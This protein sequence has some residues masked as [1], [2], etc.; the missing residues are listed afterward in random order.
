MKKKIALLSFLIITAAIGILI[1]LNTQEIFNNYEEKNVALTH[2]REVFL[3]ER[4]YHSTAEI[5]AIGDILLHDKVYEDA[6]TGSGYDFS[7]MFAPVKDMLSNPDFTIANQESI[8]AGSDL[9]LSGYP[10]FNSPYEISDT[11]KDVGI[12]LVTLANN[13]SLD[14]GEKGILRAIEYYNKIDMPYVGIHKN[15]EDAK[16]DRIM[17]VNGINIGF[18]SY[19]YGTNGIPIPDGKDYLVNYLD[20]KKVSQDIKD[21]RDKVDLILINA[22]WGLEY[23]RNPSDEQRKMAKLMS[24]AGADIIIG[25]H[26]HVLQP[27]EWIESNQK[28]TL[29]VYSLGNFISAQKNNY[30]DIGGMVTISVRKEWSTKGTETEVTNV[31]FSPTYVTNQNDRD[32]RINTFGSEDVFGQEK[33]DKEKLTDFML[34]HPSIK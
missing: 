11:L 23:Q 14:K 26:P 18:L 31:N 2:N 29:V 21:L 19:T 16:Q 10:T 9:G 30:K 32:Y 22:H 6:D 27:I 4:N 24:N 13:H 5:G 25:H 20:G 12:D 15:E 3:S 33:I 28:K 17:N 1:Y 34:S 7:D 8:A